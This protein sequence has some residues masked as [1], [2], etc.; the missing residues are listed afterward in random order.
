MNTDIRQTTTTTLNTSV[1]NFAVTNK[2]LDSP[3]SNDENYYYNTNF[4]KNLG[5]YLT[6]P[7]YKKAIDTYATWV[8]GQGI[9][10]QNA[11]DKVICDHI[12]GCGKDTLKDILVNMLV[13]KKANGDSYSEIIRDDTGQLQNL[14]PLNPQKIIHVTNKKGI[15][16]GYDYLQDD[17]KTKRFKLNEIFHL[18]NDRIGDETHGHYAG[19]SVQWVI[20]AR[21][22]AMAD[23][24]RIS[25][26]ATIRVLFIEE[27]DTTKLA[28][29]KRDYADVINKGELLI[30]PV[31]STEAQFQD[32]TIPPIQQLMLWIEYLENFFYQAVGVPKSATGGALSSTEANAKV[33]MV[34]FDPLYIEEL[35]DLE[36]DFF[37]Q[38]GIKISLTRQPSMMDNVQTDQQANTGQTKMQMQGSQ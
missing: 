10:Y 15:L 4:P 32:L 26:R 18:I 29:L 11:R 16:I 34:A 20:D 22:E 13:F 31:K 36:S 8:L 35:T 2:T 12:T 21:Q 3:T 37:S 33:G 6:I 14:K 19:E 38:V 25:H 1:K 9:T 30:L 17:G 23:I 7:E 5:Y 27:D 28:N 24:R